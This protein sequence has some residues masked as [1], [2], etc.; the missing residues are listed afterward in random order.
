M[1]RWWNG[2][3]HLFQVKGSAMRACAC[4]CTNGL[5]SRRCFGRCQLIA[6]LYSSNEGS[7]AS[8]SRWDACSQGIVI[9]SIAAIR[10]GLAGLQLPIV[11]LVAGRV[12]ER[13]TDM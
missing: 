10:A 9:G 5:Q 6:P 13:Q 3:T 2:C 1:H 12:S 11:Y 4:A 8:D 7:G